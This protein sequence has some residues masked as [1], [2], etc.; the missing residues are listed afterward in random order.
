MYGNDYDPSGHASSRRPLD[1]PD[2]GREHGRGFDPYDP[3]PTERRRERTRGFPDG[4]ES[5][6]YGRR[7]RR[8]AEDDELVDR[9]GGSP[10]D[11]LRQ[12]TGQREPDDGAAYAE[13]PSDVY[14]SG[15]GD[16]QGQE[17]PGDQHRGV[18]FVVDRRGGRGGSSGDDWGKRRRLSSPE[19]G[20]ER[21]EGADGYRRSRGLEYGDYKSDERWGQEGVDGSDE[22]DRRRVDRSHASTR[23]DDVLA[24]RLIDAS[25][26][27]DVGRKQDPVTGNRAG[28]SDSRLGEYDSLLEEYGSRHGG[29]RGGLNGYPRRLN[30]VRH[31]RGRGGR[32]G[33]GR[34]FNEGR[35]FSEAQGSQRWYDPN[36]RG[37]QRP[38]APY[39]GRKLRDDEKPKV[40]PRRAREPEVDLWCKTCHRGLQDMNALAAHLK[41]KKHAQAL[42]EGRRRDAEEEDV[43]EVEDVE[44]FHV[45]APVITQSEKDH[46]LEASHFAS[47]PKPFQ[48]WANR[49]LASARFKDTADASQRW[50]QAVMREI[51]EEL[52]LH[53]KNGSIAYQSWATREKA[54]GN[55]F[56]EPEPKVIRLPVFDASSKEK[57]LHPAHERAGGSTHGF[58]GTAGKS[59]STNTPSNNIDHI[60]T[61][62]VPQARSDP[63]GRRLVGDGAERT[64]RPNCGSGADPG[65]SVASALDKGAV[66]TRRGSSPRYHENDRDK[67]RAAAAG[68]GGNPVSELV[69]GQE[70][71]A[72][73]RSGPPRSGDRRRPKTSGES[74]DVSRRLRSGFYPQKSRRGKSIANAIVGGFPDVSP[75]TGALY[76]RDLIRSDSSGRPPLCDPL[77]SH[78]KADSLSSREIRDRVASLRQEFEDGFVSPDFVDKLN[79]LAATVEQRTRLYSN[80]LVSVYELII[81]FR[82]ARHECPDLV[83][84]CSKLMTA[85][86][87]LQNSSTLHRR[88]EFTAY[89]VMSLLLAPKKLS[90]QE[91]SRVSLPHDPQSRI[92]SPCAHLAHF[93]PDSKFY[94]QLTRHALAVLRLVVSREHVVFFDLY[95]KGSAV[96]TCSSG[97][98]IRVMMES[99]M[100]VVRSQHL[101]K[102]YYSVDFPPRYPLKD[103]MQQL[104][105][106]DG[107][108]EKLNGQEA[109]AFIARLGLSIVNKHEDNEIREDG[110]TEYVACVGSKAPPPTA[111]FGCARRDVINLG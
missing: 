58:R 63:G 12:G 11:G 3:I 42:E 6:G 102:V 15:R 90:P 99:M 86:R 71:D 106:I 33:G 18:P 110:S 53:N 29:D 100:D 89:F 101:I 49:S 39:W 85:Y 69:A 61:S 1:G 83:V 107:G 79:D 57:S 70:E 38:A 66:P 43:Q 34:N 56:L 4:D 2:R 30:P 94:G 82:L 14:R 103:A 60:S 111:L 44:R 48:D 27:Q 92:A 72:E 62:F 10:R 5:L 40:I 95:K 32:G 46:M 23:G 35:F 47:A 74:G 77:A 104:Q 16:S 64:P 17:A 98:R 75:Q 22:R 97:D 31:P 24:A 45:I 21:G 9:R 36:A 59:R 109:R 91:K 108:S 41:S 28:G 105:W 73:L 50:Q 8:A 13:R 19:S 54:T 7:R 25:P 81:E 84:P 80:S 76:D 88:D 87:A 93:L 51:V 26:D 65:H 52:C 68:C 20:T 55:Y 78:S 96:T 37:A 67:G